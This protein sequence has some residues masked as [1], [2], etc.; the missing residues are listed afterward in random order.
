[1]KVAITIDGVSKSY[2]IHHKQGPAYNTLRDAMSAGARGV[3]RKILG[4]AE[5]RSRESVPTEEV[6]WALRDVSL[7]VQSGDR[8]GIVGRNGA[9]KSTLL[10]IL[11]RITP[12]TSGEVRIRGRIASLLEVGTGFHPELTGRENIYLNGAVLGMARREIRQ[13]FDEIVAFA[14]VE[15][16]LDTPVKKYSSGMYTRL[17]F[18]VAAQLE[19]EILVVDEVLSVGDAQFQQKCLG[20]MQSVADSGRTVVYVSHNLSSVTDLCNTAVWID[21]GRI[22]SVGNPSQVVKAYLASVVSTSQGVVVFAPPGEHKEAY[23]ASVAFR[24]PLGAIATLFDVEEPIDVEIKFSVRRKFSSW[25]MFAAITRPDGITVFSTTTWDYTTHRPAVDP[26]AYVARMR[27]PAR[28]LAESTYFLT[29]A[30]GEPPI[31]R[32][33]VHENFMSFQVAGQT[34]DNKRNI[35]L[36]AYPFEWD[37]KKE[38]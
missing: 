37:V 6:F 12:P 9:G 21:N 8:V 17:A 20:K 15:K 29:V 32:H 22:R 33:D 27:I 25:R 35:G 4:G 18:A 36:L 5:E 38:D 26:G 16:F 3:V 31:K 7:Q 1:M 2:V 30:F 28:L 24:D 14:E 19:S 34:F 23:I 11:S 13:K 10:K